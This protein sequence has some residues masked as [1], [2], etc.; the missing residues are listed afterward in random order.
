ME[1]RVERLPTLRGPAYWDYLA[2]LD[3]VLDPFPYTGATTTF[4]CMWMRTPVVTLAGDCGSARSAA[5]IAAEMGLDELV[6]HG[7]DEYVAIAVRLAADPVRL[8]AIKEGLR[9]RM[10]QTACCDPALFTANLEGL[11][12]QAWA[13]WCEGGAMVEQDPPV[14][15]GG[16]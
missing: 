4:D 3:I 12:R 2:S 1:G 5:S 14:R 9:A 11:Y 13:A 10:R 7:D 15:G 6:A 8:A 16:A